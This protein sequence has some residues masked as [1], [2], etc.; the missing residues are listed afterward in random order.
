M[1]FI[2]LSWLIL[3]VT[4]LTA[5]WMFSSMIVN[6]FKGELRTAAAQFV[7]TVIFAL[8]ALSSLFTLGND[9]AWPW[10]MHMPMFGPFRQ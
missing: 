10:V 9:Y 7:A 3:F 5:L 2:F 4:G 6:L 1:Y 8:V